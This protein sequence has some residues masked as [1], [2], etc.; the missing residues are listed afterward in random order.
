M[1]KRSAPA[2]LTSSRGRVVK[3]K[4]WH[5][6]TRLLNVGSY[7][8]DVACDRSASH[9]QRCKF[10]HAVDQAGCAPFS[11]SRLHIVLSLRHFVTQAEHFLKWASKVVCAWSAGHT[12]WEGREACWCA[13]AAADLP[14]RGRKRR[15]SVHRCSALHVLMMGVGLRYGPLCMQ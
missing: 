11:K 4:L 2:A 12:V 6:G 10:T 8:L 3:P 1:R 13:M 14:A 7:A 9:K 5:D 15:S